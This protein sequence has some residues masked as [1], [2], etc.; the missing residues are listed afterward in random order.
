MIDCRINNT[1]G[2]FLVCGTADYFSAIAIFF[3]LNF[4]TAV[5]RWT[6]YLKLIQSQ[7]PFR[8]VNILTY[9]FHYKKAFAFLNFLYPLTNYFPFAG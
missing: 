1:I 9:P 3:L 2:T 7:L 8:I 5:I 4:D 6:A